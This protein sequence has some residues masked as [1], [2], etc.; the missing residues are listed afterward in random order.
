ME[1]LKELQEDEVPEVIV[2]ELLLLLQ[3]L[4]LLA[5][6]LVFTGQALTLQDALLHPLLHTLVF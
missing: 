1:E 3:P 5:G 2:E 4:L 6:K